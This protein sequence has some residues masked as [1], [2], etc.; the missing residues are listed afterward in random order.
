MIEIREI[1]PDETEFLREVL[2]AAIYFAD[3][4]KRLLVSIVFEPPAIIKAWHKN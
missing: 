4:R 1:K 3:D 2:Y